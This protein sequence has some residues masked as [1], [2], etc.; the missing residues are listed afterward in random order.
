MKKIDIVNYDRF[1]SLVECCILWILNI[2]TR[3]HISM[4]KHDSVVPYSFYNK[5]FSS[6]LLL[7]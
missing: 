7:M 1:R 3:T 2:Y 5:L 6:W 4:L